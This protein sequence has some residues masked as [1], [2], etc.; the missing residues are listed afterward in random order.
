MPRNRSRGRRSVERRGSTEI[1]VGIMIKNNLMAGLPSKTK[2]Y[3]D[4]TGMVIPPCGAFRER[5]F[6][7]RDIAPPPWMLEEEEMKERFGG[8]LSWVF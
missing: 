8:S 3:S 5:G 7:L 6:G 1:L 2:T 4:Y